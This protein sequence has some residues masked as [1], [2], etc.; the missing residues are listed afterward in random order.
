MLPEGLLVEAERL[1]EVLSQL[2]RGSIGKITEVGQDPVLHFLRS[3]VCKRNREDVLEVV[4]L[5]LEGK[6]EVFTRERAGF[7]ASRGTSVE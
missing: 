4:S 5:E 3:L 7:A 1:L 2:V 6:P